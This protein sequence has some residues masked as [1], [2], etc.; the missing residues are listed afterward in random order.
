MKEYYS[1]LFLPDGASIEDVKKA[2]RKLVKKFHPDT[3]QDTNE[4]TLEFRLIQDAYEKLLIH[5]ANNDIQK[6]NE[7]FT[8]DSKNFF[9]SI[10]KSSAKFAEEGE[11]IKSE[12]FFKLVINVLIALF[13]SLCLLAAFRIEFLLYK[14][15]FIAL[16]ASVSIAYFFSLSLSLISSLRK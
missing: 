11:M 6:P 15:A 16:A 3:N 10:V 7:N 14:I 1:R 13:L 8:K 5:L 2:Y 9:G 4:Y 12:F